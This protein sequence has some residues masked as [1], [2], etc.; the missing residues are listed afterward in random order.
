[1]VTS[2]CMRYN[3]SDTSVVRNIKK[4]HRMFVSILLL[5]FAS[6]FFF[7]LPYRVESA[8]PVNTVDIPV[9]VATAATAQSSVTL[10]IKET[11]L[12]GVVFALI[13]TIIDMIG[14]QMVSWI[15]SGFEGNPGFVTDPGGLFASAANNVAADF[16]DELG[17]GFLCDSFDLSIKFALSLDFSFGSGGY[18]TAGACTLDEIAR[19]VTS[20]E[21]ASL[22]AFYNVA[23]EPNNNVYSSYL[24]ADRELTFRISRESELLKDQLNWGR[25]FLSATDIEG[26]I[27]TPGAFVETQLNNAVG[28]GQRRLEIADEISEIIGAL[29]NTLLSSAFNGLAGAGGGTGSYTFNT[30]SFISDA[31][32]DS[33]TNTG[34]VDNVEVDIPLGTGSLY[35]GMAQNVAFNKPTHQSSR[36]DDYISDNATDGTRRNDPSRTGRNA[37]PAWWQVDLLDDYL[38]GEVHIHRSQIGNDS[39]TCKALGADAS[40]SFSVAFFTQDP[41]TTPTSLVYSTSILSPDSGRTHFV[42]SIPEELRETPIRYV[43]VNRGSCSVED[44]NWLGLA[45][46]EVY[47]VP[48]PESRNIANAGTLSSS[49]LLA[50]TWEGGNPVTYPL[51][52]LVDGKTENTQPRSD[53]KIT[54]PWPAFV[55]DEATAYSEPW[56]GISYNTPVR[57][58]EVRI[59]PITGEVSPGELLPPNLQNLKVVL[60]ASETPDAI[61]LNNST[62]AGMRGGSDFRVI[63]IPSGTRVESNGSII[64]QVPEFF[65]ADYVR[66]Q[67]ANGTSFGLGE[68]QVYG[69]PVPQF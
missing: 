63:D 56:F 50:H 13:N 64:V 27:E 12:D 8:L 32:G 1:M 40:S 33:R 66:I 57:V 19:N 18:T 53:T 29:M 6:A 46:V 23:L 58:T 24:A 65:S 21:I 7:S 2:F 51:T 5:F 16:I 37:M 31:D 42:I 39:S 34:E 20:G 11:V 26:Y 4:M 67:Q 9:G 48:V 25:G 61:G 17:L 41:I 22:D 62:V 68:V 10:Q 15:N 35:T 36:Y 45:E 47:G 54:A 69:F 38:I 30:P 52:N 14:Q 44:Y 49:G 55:T 43:R 28:S 60:A 3:V 59:F